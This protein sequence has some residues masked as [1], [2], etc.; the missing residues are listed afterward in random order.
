MA[1]NPE[2]CISQQQWLQRFERWIEQGNPQDLLN[3]SIFFDFRALAGNETL[4]QP[5]REYVMKR[6][7]ATPRF[8]KL[9]VE[10]SLQWKVPLNWFGSLETKELD[11]KNVIDIKLQGT[12]IVV[13]CARIYSLAN[14]IGAVNTRERLAAI[15]RVLQ[16]TEA[17]SQAW[18]AAFEYLQT[19]RLAAQIDAHSI[20]GNPNAVDVDQLNSVDRT[21]LRE[22]LSK[23]RNLQQHLELDYVR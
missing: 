13:D 10:N 21:I 20:A 2:L 23:V 22:S 19:L 7:Q 8:I 4:L 12:A 15:G 5:L 18:I 3:A 9:L 14:G 6:A 1:S 16:V 11:G 17:E